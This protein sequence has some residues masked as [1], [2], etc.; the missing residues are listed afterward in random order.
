MNTTPT[1]TDPRDRLAIRVEQLASLTTA[2]TVLRGVVPGKDVESLQYLAAE[3]AGELVDLS[4]AAMAEAHRA[5]MLAGTA[6]TQPS[7]G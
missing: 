4:R 2:L 6:E 5:A 7:R 3:L 1:K